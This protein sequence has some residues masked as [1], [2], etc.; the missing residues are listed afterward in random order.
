MG[1]RI[2]IY[3]SEPSA[4][5]LERLEGRSTSDKVRVVLEQ[6]DGD[7]ASIYHAQEQLII[8]LKRQLKVREIIL[9]RVLKTTRVKPILKADIEYVLGA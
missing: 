8:A 2:T 3:L 1:N 5:I 4:A 6:M 7:K 9:S